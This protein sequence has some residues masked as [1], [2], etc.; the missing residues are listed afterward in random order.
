MMYSV[1][2]T[3]EEWRE[4]WKAC[5]RGDEMDT[6]LRTTIV[7]A[8]EI[9][10]LNQSFPENAWKRLIQVS[11]RHTSKEAMNRSWSAQIFNT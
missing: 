9:G 10:Q 6:L 7:A 8:V 5:D 11:Q 1:E 3:V 4:I 2:L